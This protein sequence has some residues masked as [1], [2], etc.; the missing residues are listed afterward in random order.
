MEGEESLVDLD[1]THTQKKSIENLF[2]V[3]PSHT[4]NLVII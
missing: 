1:H 4:F 3:L 2:T